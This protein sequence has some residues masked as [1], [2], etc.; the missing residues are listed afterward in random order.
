MNLRNFILDSLKKE[1]LERLLFIISFYIFIFNKNTDHL[2]TRQLQ[3]KVLH[4]N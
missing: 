3:N 2:I 4:D 1:V